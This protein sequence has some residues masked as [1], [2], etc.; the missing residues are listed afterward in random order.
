MVWTPTRPSYMD[1]PRRVGCIWQDP[2][3]LNYHFFYRNIQTGQF[4]PDEYTPWLVN[5]NCARLYQLHNPPIWYAPYQFATVDNEG[6]LVLFYEHLIL[7]FSPD[8][9]H[10]VENS[11]IH[12]TSD[13]VATDLEYR[14]GVLP[15]PGR[16]YFPGD[17]SPPGTSAFGGG[18]LEIPNDE[19]EEAA[20][21]AV[22]LEAVA[23]PPPAPHPNT[24]VTLSLLAALL[25]VPPLTIP[26]QENPWAE[27][28]TAQ[29]P[30]CYFPK[31]TPS[32]SPPQKRVCNIVIADAV[33]KGLA[34]PITMNPLTPETAACIAPCYHVFEKEAI[35]TW[36]VDHPSCPECR[37]P[38]AL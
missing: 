26:E 27:L 6:T 22:L 12:L 2:N 29:T 11:R 3:T 20:S 5:H 32:I 25:A 21:Q 23:L 14:Q 19:E 31:A 7:P 13:P 10:C 35:K 15:L 38:C 8:S 1:T 9:Q 24:L 16:P 28:L 33:A 36:L 18:I 4:V 34:C 17:D 37:T 30:H